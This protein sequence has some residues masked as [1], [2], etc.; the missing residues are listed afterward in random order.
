MSFLRNEG[1]IQPVKPSEFST[2]EGIK[3]QQPYWAVEFELVMVIDGRNLRYEAR[4]PPSNEP[5]ATIHPQKVYAQ[6]QICI[7]AAFKPGT[8]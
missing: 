5:A 4:W 3:A 6:G 7:A 8:A 2:F 1:F